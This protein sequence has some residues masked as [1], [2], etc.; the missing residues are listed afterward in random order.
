[1]RNTPARLLTVG[2]CSEEGSDDLPEG[3]P[4][5]SRQSYHSWRSTYLQFA[6][7]LQSGPRLTIGTHAQMHSPCTQA[8]GMGPVSERA[9]KQSSL[10]AEVNRATCDAAL[11]LVPARARERYERRGRRLHFMP[12]RRASAKQCYVIQRGSPAYMLT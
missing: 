3:R 10:A 7:Q 5:M 12:D 6:L 8:L 1:M 9:V 4:S 2:H 11:R